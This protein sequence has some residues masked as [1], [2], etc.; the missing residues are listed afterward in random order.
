MDGKELLASPDNSAALVKWKVL[1]TL[2]TA[3]QTNSGQSLNFEGVRAEL[4]P[5][6]LQLI[7]EA[8]YNGY[9]TE[10]AHTLKRLK[11]HLE[12][13]ISRDELIRH[14]QHLF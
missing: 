10:L 8:G 9:S 6:V 12:I 7:R 4:L 2:K 11:D 14:T 5:I 13:S 1:Q 3:L